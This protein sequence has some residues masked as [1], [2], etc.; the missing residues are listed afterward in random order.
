[1]KEN[2]LEV[3]MY[4]FE[5][6]MIEGSE[7]Q[8]DQEALTVELSQA[9]FG[10]GEIHKAFDWLEDLSA[11]CEQPME[12]LHGGRVESMRHYSPEEHVKLDSEAQALL[13]SLEQAGILDPSAREFV[14]DRVM[15]LDGDDIDIEHIR[16]VTMMVLCNRPDRDTV[17]SWAEDLVLDGIQAHLH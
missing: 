11:M 5:N 17:Y 7:F 16:W 2:V 4:L 15:A 1:M 13:L 12:T 6:Y 14:I 8:P 10:H 3:L 9:G